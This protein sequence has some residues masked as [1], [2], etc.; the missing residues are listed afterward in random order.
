MKLEICRA[1]WYS[2]VLAQQV[3]NR[4]GNSLTKSKNQVRFYLH[5]LSNTVTECST[6]DT[7]YVTL[8]GKRSN[9]WPP[10]HGSVGTT[11]HDQQLQIKPCTFLEMPAGT[12]GNSTY[13]S[14]RWDT[15]NSQEGWCDWERQ[16]LE[17]QLLPAAYSLTS[18]VGTCL[19]V[20]GCGK[21]IMP[22]LPGFIK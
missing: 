2:P 3:K 7:K 11:L 13:T 14:G 16:D 4:Q 1:D 22:P 20:Q 19:F 18:S 10:A 5:H 6:P 9:S 12:E 8:Q 17:H 21:L 15:R